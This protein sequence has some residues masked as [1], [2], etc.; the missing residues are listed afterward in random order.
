MESDAR[1]EFSAYL[2]EI[3]SAVSIGGDASRIK[4]DV[5]ETDIAAVV[6]L[7]AF[8][9]GKALRVTVEYDDQPGG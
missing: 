2:P 8:G 7:A 5:P 4:L 6:K 1:I 9:R 3:Q